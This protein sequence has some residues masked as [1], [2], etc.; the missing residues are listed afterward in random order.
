MNTKT[1]GFNKTLIATAITSV[2]LGATGFAHAQGDEQIEEII[3]T[4]IK[5]SLQRAMDIK[6]D[7]AGVVD[8]ISAEDI[9][10]FPDTNLAESLQRITGVSIDRVNG[11]GSRVTVRGFGPDYNLVTLNGRQMPA[12]SI[13]DTSASSSRSFDFSN[14]ASEGISGVEVYKSGRASVTSGGIGATINIL[15]ARPLNNPGLSAS[16][17]VKGVMDRSTDEGKTVTPEISGIYSQTFADDTIGVSLSGSYQERESGS[18]VASTGAGWHVFPGWVN[19]DWGGG[20]AEW[21]GIP[22]VGHENRPG[23]NDIY[24]VPQQLQYSFNEVQRT[25]TNGQLAVQFRPVDNLTA[26]LDYTYSEQEFSQQAHD[27]S[28]WFNFGGS[29]GVWT[30][31]PVS[32][33]IIYAEQT[34]HADLAMGAGDFARVNENN[35]VGLNLEWQVNDRL[36]LELDAHHSDAESRPDGPF[37][38]H[39]TI[40]VA[41]WVRMESKADFSK[42]FPVLT[43]QYPDGVTAIDPADIRVAGSS[44]R[45]SYSKSEI[46]QIQLKGAFEFDMGSTLSFGVAST[47]VENHSAYANVQRDTWGGVGEAGDFDNSFWVRDTIADK[48]D[49]PGSNNPALQSELY[50]FNFAD[51]RARAEALYPE[52]SAS[53]PAGDCGTW[54]CPSTAYS[55]QTDRRTEEETTSAYLQYHQPIDLGDRRM[56]VLAGLRYE[57]TDV[58]S[59]AAVPTYDGV[60]W[61]SDN[62]MALNAT[63]QQDYF[64]E[65]GSYD[66]W[67]PN[68]DVDIEVI[69]DVIL[70]ASFSETIARPS[71]ADLQAGTSVNTQARVNGG[72]GARGNAGLLPFESTNFDLSAEWYYDEGSYMSVG[73][74][75]KDVKNFI[76]TSVVQE[77]LMGL[78]NPADG[79]R[80]RAAVA[81]VGSTDAGKIREYMIA[82]GEGVSGTDIHAIASD[83]PLIF[84]VTIPVNQKEASIDGWEVAVQHLFGD[85]GFGAIANYTKVSGDIDF[86]K[87]SLGDQFALLGLSDSANLVAFYDKNGLQ[88]RLAYNWRDTFL[89]S[90]FQGTGMPNPI[91]V[92]SYGQ[93]D[94]NVSYEVNDNLTVFAEGINI[95]DEYTRSHGR[96]KM[97]VFNVVQ[98]GPRYNIGVRYNF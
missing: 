46:D 32:S 91:Y 98:L 50:R 16:V 37:G 56:N 8:A 68:I 85:S 7:A 83:N 75:K 35:S 58:T 59:V 73:W 4:G 76:G 21:G 28:A 62:E 13:E 15:T 17:G 26:T 69:D 38:S 23:P 12:S 20:T 55:S 95:T 27:I 42:D 53:T 48:F 60:T 51:L 74:F 88:A 10:K 92:E 54:F 96:S 44:F 94:V 78:R 47:T 49:I 29:T 82:Q 67:L 86:D 57:S 61:V 33:P 41:T 79:E 25:R 80:Y 72:T 40:G 18:K 43:I 65:T 34:D 64:R 70:R 45:N 31:G 6:R 89:A 71:Y 14:L 63:G 24:S 77:Q 22:D 52:P 5:G 39:N 1:S 11:E 19:Q 90:T 9:G 3:V 30:D 87:T 93:F 2:M 84:D 97:Q 36:S 66:H 81:A